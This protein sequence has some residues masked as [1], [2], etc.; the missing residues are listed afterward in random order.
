M[1]YMVTFTINI[2]QILAYIPYMD[3]MGICLRSSDA[4]VQG[5]LA[6]KRLLCDAFHRLRPGGREEQG[7]SLRRS[8]NELVRRVKRRN[9]SSKKMEEKSWEMLGYGNSSPI[10]AIWH[11]A[12]ILL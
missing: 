2:P 12:I 9:E 7:L 11:I 6:T 1:P 3:S 10:M 4:Y 5:A 8:L